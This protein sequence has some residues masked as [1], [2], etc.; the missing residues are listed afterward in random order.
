VYTDTTGK[1]IINGK[2]K[3]TILGNGVI[4]HDI[5]FDGITKW[6]PLPQ[7]LSLPYNNNN[8]T[9]NFIGVH[10][11]SRNHIKYQYKLQ[12]LEEN[13]SSITERTEAPYGNLPAGDYTFKVKAMNQS[14]V[15]SEPFE[16][17]FIVRP[18]WWQTWLFRIIVIVFVIACIWF[19]IKSREKKL[20]AE[21][22]KLEKTVEERTAE[23]VKQKDVIEEQKH[24][25]E[26]KHK[27]ITDSINY[28]E[29]IQRS[30]LASDDLLKE[31]FV[32][33]Q[34]KDVVSGDFYWASKLSND[35]FALVTADSTG[36]G[37]PGA[38]MSILNI[39]C[40]KESV[41]EG[42]LEPAEILNNTRKLIIETLKKDG[43]SEGGKD[44]MDGSLISFDLKNSKL[45]YSA[46][47]NPVWIVRGKDLLEFAHDKM[48]V[49]KHNRDN[50]PFTQHTIDLQKGD[51]V[52]AI[53][54]GMP[55]Q[56]GG[57][58]GKKF[59]YKQLKELLISI[60]PLPM[61]EQKEKLATTLNNW[62]GNLEQ[63]DDVCIIGVRV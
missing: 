60:A 9:F 10:I 50:V 45:T 34:P 53:T 14:G 8:L 36:H 30:L 19:Y 6:Y 46:A 18:P 38:I 57:P 20:V 63:V 51:L 52:Y 35:N 32:F 55:D 21:K 41:K 24:F 49:G 44:G 28:A 11:Q 22:E 47:N 23:V 59:M 33:F 15:W 56:F 58:K 27:E 62:K 17:N 29:R 26:E 2:S 1:E 31:Y 3:D 4:L 48:P 16:F 13:W 12:G 40:L 39:S 25:V 7:N 37:V 54:D 42:V 5:Q 43:S 61:S